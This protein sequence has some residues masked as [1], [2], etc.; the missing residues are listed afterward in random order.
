MPYI[1]V[2]MEV[3]VRKYEVNTEN[4]KKILKQHKA[5]SS[6]KIADLLGKPKH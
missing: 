5:M 2:E 6:E 3:S 1:D 4:L